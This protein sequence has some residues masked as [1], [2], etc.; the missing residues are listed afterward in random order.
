MPLKFVVRDRRVRYVP[1]I[2]SANNVC[3][4]VTKLFRHILPSFGEIQ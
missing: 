4:N 3:E 1:S 2:V